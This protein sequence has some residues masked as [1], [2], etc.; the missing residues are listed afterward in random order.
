V[1]IASGARA[2]QYRLGRLPPPEPP[3]E[4][5][6]ADLHRLDGMP[7]AVLENRE[8]VKLILPALKADASLYR[9][10]LYFEEPPLN[11]AIRA[12]GGDRDPNVS[13]EQLEAWGR[14][15]AGS[16]AVRLFPG[17]HFFLQTAQTALWPALAEDLEGFSRG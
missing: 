7:T 15:T 2:P 16:F 3:D 5:L 4:A 17:G 13:R 6:L 8:L 14:Q 11:C 10:Y 9:N 1:L 12:Y